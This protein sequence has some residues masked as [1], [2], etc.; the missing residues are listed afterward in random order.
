MKQI[1]LVIQMGCLPGAMN[2]GIYS[3]I[4]PVTQTWCLPMALSKDITR[5]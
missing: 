5:I 3:D 2:L 4:A 1:V